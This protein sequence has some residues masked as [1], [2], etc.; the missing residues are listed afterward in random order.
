MRQLNGAAV[1]VSSVEMKDSVALISMGLLS[2]IVRKV[3][4]SASL[5]TSSCFFFDAVTDNSGADMF[6]LL[7]TLVLESEDPAERVCKTTSMKYSQH[8]LIAH[9]AEETSRFLVSEK[10]KS[11]FGL[12][13]T[14][15]EQFT[16]IL[17]SLS[18]Q[19]SPVEDSIEQLRKRVETLTVT[20]TVK[21]LPTFVD[22]SFSAIID[23]FAALE[24]Q[25]HLAAEGFGL[26]FSPATTAPRQYPLN[27]INFF[28]R[29]KRITDNFF[30]STESISW[31]WPSR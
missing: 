31:P 25:I 22:M 28:D 5:S 1:D 14:T 16:N 13:T 15:L 18:H 11:P 19:S 27:V 4:S 17:K 3:N 26:D 30:A 21:L 20:G 24:K 7:S 8:A 10:L 6:R 9:T 12:A 23:F 2:M 29:S